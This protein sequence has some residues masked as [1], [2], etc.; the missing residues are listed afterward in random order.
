MSTFTA[1]SYKGT[2]YNLKLDGWLNHL[3]SDIH[4]AL[5]EIDTDEIIIMEDVKVRD[6][7][8]ITKA[9][10]DLLPY[11][12][13]M[14]YK[15]YLDMEIRNV[16]GR[17]WGECIDYLKNKIDAAYKTVFRPARTKKMTREEQELLLMAASNGHI[18]AMYFIGTA[19]AAKD[20][21][22]NSSV[23]WLSK[24]HNCGYVAASYALSEYFDKRGCVVDS[25]R[26]LILAAD[27]GMDQAY[28]SIFHL[29]HVKKLANYGNA[30]EVHA[31][32]DEFI[33]ARP[34]SIARFFKSVMLLADGDHSG[35]VKM[36]KDIYANPKNKSAKKTRV[37]V[38][39]NQ[40]T[41]TKEIVGEILDAIKNHVNPLKAIFDACEY[42]GA[43]SYAAH[44]EL[45]DMWEK[46]AM[47]KSQV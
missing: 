44:R 26:C 15:Q 3:D 4:V 25:L 40:A 35:G 41:N 8:K 22:D 11:K 6:F 1:V 39:K 24:A 23:M 36:L 12:Q 30:S 2:T 9:A 27:K 28:M 47:E 7:K 16:Y 20:E 43:V 31:M 13:G 29:E 17:D 19:L 38:E 42:S 46:A 45:V 18:A 5:A 32:L 37:N 10:Y 14:S 21:E 34:F 33:A